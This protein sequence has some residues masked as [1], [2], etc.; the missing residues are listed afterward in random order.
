M[1]NYYVPADDP[2][3]AENVIKFDQITH[4][5]PLRFFQPSPQ[6]APW[7]IQA[8]ADCGEGVEPIILN[9]WPHRMKG[10]RQWH[11][12]IEGELAI[13]GIIQGALEEAEEDN[14]FDVIED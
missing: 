2:V 5:Y 13:H 4:L 7:H 14:S 8:V 9:F 3:A 12:A 6:K 1:I 10:Q 11:Q